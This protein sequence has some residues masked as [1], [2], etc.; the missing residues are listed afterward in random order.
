MI[1]RRVQTE[2]L[3]DIWDVDGSGYLEINEVEMVL[4]KWREE[5]IHDYLLKEACDVFE[6]V[7]TKITRK[8]FKKLIDKICAVFTEEDVFDSL[9]QF[10]TRSVQVCFLLFLFYYFGW[11]SDFPCSPVRR[12]DF[13]ST[14][15][16]KN[17]TKTITGGEGI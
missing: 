1:K 11:F 14:L 16:T 4:S 7:F 15:S 12:P 6:D 10:L 5:D 3:F 8:S 17:T 13:F 9:I 2:Q